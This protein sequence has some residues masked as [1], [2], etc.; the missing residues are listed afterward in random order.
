MREYGTD[1]TAIYALCDKTCRNRSGREKSLHGAIAFNCFPSPERLAGWFVVDGSIKDITSDILRVW[2]WLGAMVDQGR[3]AKP[4]AGFGR[5]KWSSTYAQLRPS[6]GFAKLQ[7]AKPADTGL[8]RQREPQ[9]SRLGLGRRWDRIT[10][11][12]SF[13]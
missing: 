7:C 5:A 13:H 8:A 11:R 3:R 10:S 4:R 9:R 12:A 1:V 2:P 6:A